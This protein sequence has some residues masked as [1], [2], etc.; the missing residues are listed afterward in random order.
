MAAGWS[1]QWGEWS[2]NQFFRFTPQANS[3]AWLCLQQV[4]GWCR[5][6]G[7][8]VPSPSGAAWA[9]HEASKYSCTPGFVIPKV[10]DSHSRNLTRL[11][12]T[13]KYP[14]GKAGQGHGKRANGGGQGGDAS[15]RCEWGLSP[16]SH[17]P[18]TSAAHG[19]LLALMWH[20]QQQR[21]A[22][23]TPCWGRCPHP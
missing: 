23:P 13:G 14:V 6:G 17:C 12:G 19:H 21:P 15:L 4:G 20:L 18:K 7:M 2:D 8:E 3:Q 16:G 11:P 5:A 9:W 10:T 1:E 22:H